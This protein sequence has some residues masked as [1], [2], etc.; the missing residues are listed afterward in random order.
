M[1]SRLSRSFRQKCV[2]EVVLIPAE[3]E[4]QNNHGKTMTFK[5]PNNFLLPVRPQLPNV[6]QP[7][8]L[9]SPA[10]T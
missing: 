5:G 7:S 3:Q 9:V 10:E 4:A 6:P 8:K 2:E 1:G